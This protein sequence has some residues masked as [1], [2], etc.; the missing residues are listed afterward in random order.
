MISG[1]LVALEA[2]R[3]TPAGIPRVMAKLSHLSQQNE[4]GQLRKVACEISL[5]AFAEVA[6]QLSQLTVGQQVKVTGFLAQQS[7][8]SRQLV[9]HINDIIL[10]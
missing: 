5:L 9:V 7:Y 3:F 6:D 10:E 4:A 8:R 1:Q 2:L